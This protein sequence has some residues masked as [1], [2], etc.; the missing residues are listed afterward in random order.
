L[1]IGC[2]VKQKFVFLWHLLSW[3][4]FL[5]SYKKGG[6]LILDGYLSSFGGHAGDKEVHMFQG[7]HVELN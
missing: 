7:Q 2:Y 4:L 3:F 5:A 1:A 6:G